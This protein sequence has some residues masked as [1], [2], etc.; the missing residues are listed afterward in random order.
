M[1]LA[2]PGKV[3]EIDPSDPLM[4]QARVSFGGVV[5][6][7]SLALLPEAEVGSYVLAHAGIAIGSVDEEEAGH[8]FEALATLGALEEETG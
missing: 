5:R 6:E 7:I 4:R 1:C 3:L 8:I 2:V